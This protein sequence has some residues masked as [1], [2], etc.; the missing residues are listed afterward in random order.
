LVGIDEAIRLAAALEGVHRG[1]S[2]GRMQW[3]YQG[4]LVARQL[5]DEHLGIRADF[6]YCDQI[7]RLFPATFSVPTRF[8]KPRMLAADFTAGDNGAIEDT[9]EAARALQCRVARSED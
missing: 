5:D 6:E 2:E 1:E 3:R 7:V 8:T 4:R 9:L